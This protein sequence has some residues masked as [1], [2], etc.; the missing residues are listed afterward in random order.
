VGQD[1]GWDFDPRQQMLAN[2]GT[3]P[4]E[5][6]DFAPPRNAPM[7]FG[8]KVALGLTAVWVVGVVLTVL[9]HK[10]VRNLSCMFDTTK[11]CQKHAANSSANVTLIGFVLLVIVSVI[12]IVVFEIRRDKR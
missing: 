12:T 6:G 9:A 3:T 8:M 5:R 4:A 2:K 11:E 7:P 1:G 10:F